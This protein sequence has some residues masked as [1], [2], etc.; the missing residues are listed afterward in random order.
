MKFKEFLSGSNQITSWL[1]S[2]LRDQWVVLAIS[3]LGVVFVQGLQLYQPFDDAFITFR[4]ARNLSQGLGFVYNPGQH[5]LGTTSPLYTL[6]LALLAW[7]SN[8]DLLPVGSFLISIVADALNVWLIY[9][10]AEWIFK[11]RVIAGL[12]AIIFLLQPFRL[13]VASGGMETSLFITFL[14]SSYDRY[15]LGDRSQSTSIW[16]A[17]AI[18]TRPDAVLA[19]IPLFIDWFFNDRKGFFRSAAL[20]VLYISPWLI[21]SILYFGTPI[22]HSIIAKTVSYK[23]PAGLG[24]YYLLTFLG[25]GTIGPYLTPL[26]L[27]PG[28]LFGLPVIL[29]G[30][31]NLAKR[32]LSGLVVASYPLLY[33]LVMSLVNPAMYFSWYYSPLIPGLIFLMIAA[34]WYSPIKKRKP[35]ISII[36]ILALYLLVFPRFLLTQSPTWPLSRA[37]E[38][39]FWEVCAK[40]SNEN[41]RGKLVLTPDI[42]VLGWCLE[43]VHI[44]DPIG[45]VS[46]EAINYS[47]DLPSGQYISPQ[48]ITDL[49]PDY[50]ISLDQFVNPF[51]LDDSGFQDA[52]HLI[53]Q[54][55]VQIEDTVQSLYV[56][57]RHSQ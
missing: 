27:I 17:L 15:L 26:Y 32:C 43:N 18:L 45:I 6:I 24:V 53:Y 35:R 11:D 49:E 40:M 54:S 23:E 34:V 29:I 10:L 33:A 3:F 52:Y 14:L 41:I 4:Y 50:L 28:L 20:T 39:A 44:L 57:S 55:E 36:F 22:P 21:W 12:A 5:V 19:L 2:A 7:L 30:F 16:S 56:F 42:G 47:R 9:R 13:N 25:T 31:W 1:E 46:P 48:L 8:P 51:I 37:R 38:A